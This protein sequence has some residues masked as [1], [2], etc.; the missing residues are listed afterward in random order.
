MA[1][2]GVAHK[3]SR[4]LNISDE[5]AHKLADAGFRVPKAIK[6]AS[7]KKL[8]EDAGLTQK[9]ADKAKARWV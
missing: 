6:K 7:K 3:L 2:I 9:E 8:R 4:H 5:V 1:R